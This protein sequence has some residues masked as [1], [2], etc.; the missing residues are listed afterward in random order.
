MPLAE[1]IFCN[2]VDLIQKCGKTCICGVQH[3]VENPDLPSIPLPD[4]P[5]NY[6]MVSTGACMD[7]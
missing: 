4:W 7:G 2:P 5:L 6:K 3:Q 1:I